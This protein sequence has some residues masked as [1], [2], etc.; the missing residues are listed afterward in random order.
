M[1]SVHFQAAA[2][3]EIQSRLNVIHS[4]Y[5]RAGG[6]HRRRWVTDSLLDC[7]AVQLYKYTV[8]RY[9][10]TV[11]RETEAALR[12]SVDECIWRGV[13]VLGG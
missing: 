12:M 6:Q 7:T 13:A 10:E 1:T 3:A 5:E 11:L 8:Y 9:T 2:H 4:N